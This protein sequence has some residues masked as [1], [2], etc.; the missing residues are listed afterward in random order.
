MQLLVKLVIVLLFFCLNNQVW[1]AD[2]IIVHKDKRMEVLSQMQAQVNKFTA[3]LSSGGQYR[4]YRVQ[5]I[6]TRKRDDA[7]A[8]K[9]SLLTK[10]PDQKTYVMFQS[11]NFKVRIGNFIKREDAEAFRNLLAGLFPQALYIVDDAIDYT[12][13]ED[14]ELITQ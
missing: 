13:P 10:F 6:S 9:T 12:P 8:I 11:P 5:V 1:A 14:E 3:M 2:S 4:G 7:F